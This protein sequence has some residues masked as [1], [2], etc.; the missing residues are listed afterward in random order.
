[1]IAAPEGRMDA[2]HPRISSFSHAVR[3]GIQ[4]VPDPAPPRRYLGVSAATGRLGCDALV[5]AWFAEF[6]DRTRIGDEDT[7]L[8]AFLSTSI[9]DAYPI[10]RVEMAPDC[11]LSAVDCPQPVG[12]RVVE[13]KI[14]HLQDEHGYTREQVAAWLETHGY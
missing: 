2:K 11:P 6:Y 10:L 14:V 9:V 12:G 8:R 3:A 4:L 5:A 1:M 13:A 7:G